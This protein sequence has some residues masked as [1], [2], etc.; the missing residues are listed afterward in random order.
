MK[1]KNGR[2][3]NDQTVPLLDSKVKTNINDSDDEERPAEEIA[4]P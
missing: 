2:N 1:S 3:D 4:Q